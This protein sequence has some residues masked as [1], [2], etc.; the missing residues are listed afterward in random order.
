MISNNKLGPNLAWKTRWSDQFFY[1]FFQKK[2]SVRPYIFLL[3]TG[4]SSVY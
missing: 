2:G 1:S 3:Y 4:S